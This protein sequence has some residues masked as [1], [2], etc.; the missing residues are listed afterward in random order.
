MLPCIGNEGVPNEI[1]KITFHYMNV[2][3]LPSCEFHV[4]KIFIKFTL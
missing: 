1:M 4:H 3:E 2:F